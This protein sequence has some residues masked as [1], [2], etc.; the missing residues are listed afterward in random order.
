M[1]S[2]PNPSTA[3]RVALDPQDMHAAIAAFPDHLREGWRRGGAADAFDLSPDRYDGVLVCGMGGSAIGGDLLR[4]LGEA[5]APV[6]IQVV[7]G[8]RLPAWVGDRTLVVASSYSGG[9]E[10][11]LSAFADA[12]QRGAARLVVASGGALMEQADAEGLP[13]IAIP[14]GLQPRAALGYSL[15]VLLRLGRSL[16]LVELPDATVD[17]AADEASLRARR[18]AEGGDARDLAGALHGT[19][20]VVYSGNGLLEA[21][22]LRWRNQLHENAKTL[23]Y[24]NLFPELNHNEIVGF[25]ATPSEVMQ[26]VAVVALRDREDHPQVQRRFDVTREIVEPRVAGWH[27]VEAVGQSRLGRVLSLLQLGDWVSY[28]LAMAQ[29]VDPTPVESIQRLKATLARA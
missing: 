13:R 8:Y 20:P 16:G 29:E 22:N 3:P 9:T 25:E 28:W 1:P 17:A 6:P 27:E 26:R 7:R 23:A 4:T 18:Y 11:T 15:G 19:L 12:R 5:E 2:V 24:G 14:G 10:E 21:V